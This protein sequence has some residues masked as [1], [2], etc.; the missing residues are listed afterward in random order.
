[1]RITFTQ[2]GGFAGLVKGCRIDTPALAAD[3]RAQVEALVAAAG[4]TESWQRFSEGR[5]RWQYD[6]AI[7]RDASHVHVVCDDSLLPPVARPLV[8]YLQ[9]RAVPQKPE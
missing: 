9:D 1:M 4:L 3:E 2:S 8:A 5:D 7:D 6:I